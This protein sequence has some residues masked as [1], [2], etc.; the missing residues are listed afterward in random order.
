MGCGDDQPPQGVRGRHAVGAQQQDLIDEGDPG[1][2]LLAV[3]R[4]ELPAAAHIHEQARG[5]Q[6]E[7]RG[8]GTHEQERDPSAGI[9][10][11][12]APQPH[13]QHDVAQPLQQWV[14]AREDQARPHV[15]DEEAAEGRH[16]EV[17]IAQRS[18]PQRVRHERRH[19]EPGPR[20]HPQQPGGE[21]E[22]QGSQEEE[23]PVVHED[24]GDPRGQLT[25]EQA[26]ERD[27]RAADRQSRRRGGPG[28][29][30]GPGQHR[31]GRE[32]DRHPR[33]DREEGR[34]AALQM[35][36]QREGAGFVDPGE[37]VRRH[38]PEQ[39]ETAGQI[40]AQDAG[41]PGSPGGGAPGGCDRVGGRQVHRGPSG[42]RAAGKIGVWP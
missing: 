31:A 18:G 29:G 30:A 21:P 3:E 28:A 11:V 26:D 17:A 33:E 15:R 10:P 41:G 13:P 22:E 24:D 4:L 14:V 40:D 20:G 12:D 32:D 25:Q 2:P 34:G 5:R 38:H 39:G 1:V 36:D 19:E 35:A 27:E 7:D 23:R 8:R 37:D 9:R 6:R 16:D 42:G